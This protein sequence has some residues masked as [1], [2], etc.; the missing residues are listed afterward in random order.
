MPQP[1]LKAGSR[2]TTSSKSRASSPSM[3]TSAMSKVRSTRFSCQRRPQRPA[4]FSRGPWPRHW[5]LVRHTGTCEQQSRS[6]WS[7]ISPGTSTD[8]LVGRKSG[9]LGEVAPSDTWPG[10]ALPLRFGESARPGRSAC[11]PG[12]TSQTPLSCNRRPMMMGF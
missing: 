2:Y 12:A 4:A 1:A 11:P 9:R 10:L 3:V 5:A 7:S 8:D 6:Q